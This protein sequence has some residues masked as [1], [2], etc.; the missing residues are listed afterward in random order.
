MSGWN[1]LRR[2]HRVVGVAAVGLPCVG[3]VWAARPCTAVPPAPEVVPL[4]DPSMPGGCFVSA[5]YGKFVPNDGYVYFRTS[6]NE[7]WR[8]NGQPG[9]Y[10]YV[11][12]VTG[13]VYRGGTVRI[14]AGAITDPL[15]LAGAP[16]RRVVYA[17]SGWLCS[18]GVDSSTVALV[19]PGA[20]P[21]LVVNGLV[22]FT[23]PGT[24]S[25]T[26]LWASNGSAGS[27]WQVSSISGITSL[28]VL[29]ATN[30]RIFFET[31]TATSNGVL[32]LW[33]ANGVPGEAQPLTPLKS[34]IAWGEFA[35]GTYRPIVQA[36]GSV[37]YYTTSDARLWVSDGTSTGTRI[38]SSI[39]GSP[40]LINALW[41]DAGNQAL[42]LSTRPNGPAQFWHIGTTPA[43]AA[44]LMNFPSGSTPTPLGIAN[45]ISVFS[46]TTG[47]YTSGPATLW[48][49]DGSQDHTFAIPGALANVNT[50]SAPP[51]SMTVGD[52]VWFLG[53]TSPSDVE[54]WRINCRTGQIGMGADLHAGTAG[55]APTAM[56]PL[57][58][59][60]GV[61]IV[62]RVA[63]DRQGIWIVA[64]SGGNA[65]PV[66]SGVTNAP[67]VA[68]V[69]V[70][71][72]IF[73]GANSNGTWAQPYMIDLCPADY[74]NSGSVGMEDLAA[75]LRDWFAGVH[76]QAAHGES[77]AA[78]RI[79]S[80]SDLI[81]F[82]QAWI[83]GCEP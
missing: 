13:A 23:A 82:V 67:P 65:M 59:G 8:S 69:S 7:L 4:T 19:H 22:F 63:S 9:T 25:G 79:P 47:Y 31:A 33:S 45:G 76:V 30:S 54:P 72:R 36:A 46:V 38:A 5:A 28:L 17:R 35:G 68:P 6:L 78:V 40:S 66:Q 12:A 24:P 73:Y 32:T 44:L 70:G 39:L 18:A 34:P 1:L 60:R 71:S 61:G 55:L 62:G 21:A 48:V 3:S 26:Q 56:I 11:N 52:C 57:D 81:G 37:F 43:A 41:P 74:D 58:G 64:P 42:Y 80:L 51:L 20:T 29:G 83:A 14:D 27:A 77:P 15:V 10:E 2:G 53:R 16:D 50:G 49:T 75:Y